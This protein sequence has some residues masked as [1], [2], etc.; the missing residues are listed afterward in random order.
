MLAEARGEYESRGERTEVLATDARLAE[1]LLLRGDADAALALATNA[2]T[3]ALTTP[4]AS[5]SIP[6]LRRVRGTAFLLAGRLAEAH[7]ALAEA[8]REARSQKS[9]Y[10]LALTLDALAEAKRR[11]GRPAEDVERERD[12]IFERLGVVQPPSAPLADA[13]IGRQPP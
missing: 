3:R 6:T 12:R 7:P 5:I 10:E 13:A 1:C 8:E 9:D 2:L 4:G 11:T